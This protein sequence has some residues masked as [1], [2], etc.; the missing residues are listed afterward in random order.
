M[1]KHLSIL[2][3]SSIL[4]L[5]GCE[6]APE[7]VQGH[8][9]KAD[10]K[11]KNLVIV[12]ID[13]PRYEDTWGDPQKEHIPYFANEL[14]QQGVHYSNFY[15]R[16][17]TYTTSGH[18]AL[19]TGNYQ[20]MS[21]D[22]SEVPLHP[23]IFQLW[24]QQNLENP[25]KAQIIAGKEKLKVLADCADPLWRGRFN[26]LTETKNRDDQETF[27]KALEISVDNL[28]LFTGLT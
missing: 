1:G 10:F 26:P 15:N 8:P 12:V 19:T 23:S 17:A 13:G 2:I 4:I 25:R 6:S 20:W 14:A 9:S 5:A 18:T 28:R 3:V 24:L 11:T 16:G 27:E 21:N 22:G 7:I